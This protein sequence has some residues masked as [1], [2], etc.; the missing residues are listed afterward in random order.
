MRHPPPWPRAHAPE[1]LRFV[2]MDAVGHRHAHATEIV[3]VAEAFDLEV[4]RVEVEA[5]VSLG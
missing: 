5:A 4:L 3:V 1:R 2:E